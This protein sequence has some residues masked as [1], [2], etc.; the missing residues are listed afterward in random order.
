MKNAFLFA[1]VTAFVIPVLV[2][3]APKP[4]KTV[5]AVPQPLTPIT[6]AEVHNAFQWSNN[7]YSG[8]C[9]ANTDAGFKALAQKGI[10]TII[11]VD[12]AQPNTELAGK[13]GMRYVHI[14]VEYSGIA[15][16]DALKIIRAARDLPGPVFI[17]CHHG[18]HRGP[19]AAALAAIALADFSNQ[20]ADF[21]LR[22]A[23]T[24]ANYKGLW[25]DVDN[26]KIPTQAEI[27]AADASFPAKAPISSMT[28]AMISIDE[29][30]EGLKTV[31]KSGWK[32]NADHP[33]LVPSHEAL[34]LR[35]HY[36][37]L[38][39][40]PAIAKFPADFL[41]KLDA[42]EVNAR[43]LETILSGKEPDKI[44]KADAALGQIKSDCGSC[45][46]LYRDGQMNHVE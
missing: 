8:S 1:V 45:H 39:R 16:E 41:T 11:T 36:T 17:H 9:P 42:A 23:G 5:E 4:P 26:F 24:G 18:L 10:K 27:D 40:S 22:Q 30:F 37:E 21:A 3:A 31:Q 35:E 7:L 14:P 6:I 32:P 33:D 46:K 25:R 28:S 13:Y 29:R 2:V 44:E 19:A 38:K 15:R 43:N 20:K 12:G 34:L